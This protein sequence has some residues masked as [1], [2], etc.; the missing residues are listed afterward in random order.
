MTSVCVV[1][2]VTKREHKEEFVCTA[3]REGKIRVTRMPQPIFEQISKV[4]DL[5]FNRFVLDEGFVAEKMVTSFFEKCHRSGGGDGT[6]RAWDCLTG[7]QISK[8][9]KVSREPSARLV[10]DAKR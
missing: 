2:G 6:I 1:D 10:R 7:K 4:Q 5:T 9:V 3:D 8:T